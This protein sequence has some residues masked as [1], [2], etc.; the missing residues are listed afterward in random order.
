MFKNTLLL[1]PL[2]LLLAGCI[3]PASRVDPDAVDELEPIVM[4][5]APPQTEGS[6]WTQSRGGMFGDN[7]GRTVGDIITVVISESASASKEATTSTDRSSNMSAGI[8]T[9]FGLE[10]SIGRATDGDPSALVDATTTNKFAGSG[11]TARKE[12]LV[13]TLTTQ[14]VEVLPN[15]NLRI[16][17]N[18][19]VTVNNEMQIVKLSGIVRTNDITPGNLVD[20]AS[21]LNARIAYVG[22]GVISDKQQQGWLVRALDQVWPF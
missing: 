8:S 15:G 14:V 1:I 2:I 11:K 10:R 5:P 21:I 16:A 3:G 20:S 12:N 17:G 9:L 6:L 22:K 7:K 18:K 19:T 13:A 4:E